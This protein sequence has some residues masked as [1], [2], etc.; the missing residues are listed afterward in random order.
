MKNWSAKSRDPS[1]LTNSEGSMA[2]TYKDQ[3][4][5]RSI[6]KTET[7]SEPNK[8]KNYLSQK[9]YGAN[10]DYEL[11]PDCGGLTNFQSGFLVCTECGWVDACHT[12]FL[13]QVITSY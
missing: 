13:D 10:D 5:E 2:R 3:K 7:S 9:R 4:N 12:L 8:K 11:C 6:R 1:V